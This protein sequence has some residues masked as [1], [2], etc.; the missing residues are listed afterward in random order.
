[1][2]N[3]RLQ[4]AIYDPTERA[5]LYDY[6]GLKRTKDLVGIDVMA[7]GSPERGDKGRIRI[8]PDSCGGIGDLT[9]PNAVAR[10]ALSD[11][12]R[13]LPQWYVGYGN[14]KFILGRDRETIPRR[15]VL[16]KP[17]FLFAINWATSGPGYSWPVS[18]HVTWIPGYDRFVVTFSA[19]SD[20]AY[21]YADVAI[22]HFVDSTPLL[23]GCRRAIKR[24]WR[25]ISDYQHKWEEFLS[26]GLVDEALADRWARGILRPPEELY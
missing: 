7:P 8:R 23:D 5:I 15:E 16:L 24:F 18:H 13:Q 25:S 19:D 9:L 10:L 6:F 26:A 1:M 14:G 20:E 12:Q 2:P 22:G 17:V 4:R 21:G 11:I 3:A